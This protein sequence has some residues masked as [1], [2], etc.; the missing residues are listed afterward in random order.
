MRNE[1]CEK[2][3]MSDRYVKGEFS[4]CRPCHT[5]AQKRYA[6]RKRIGDEA[7]ILKPPAVKLSDMAM[8]KV[9]PIKCV[10]GHYLTGNNVRMSSQRHGRNLRRRCRACE[11]TAKRVLYGLAPEPS[12][13]RLVDLLDN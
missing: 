4:Y 10:N 1:P 2:C 13:V 5:E 6:A 7:A 3:G 11:R 9:L 12:S 8:D